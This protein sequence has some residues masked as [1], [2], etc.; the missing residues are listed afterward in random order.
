[1]GSIDDEDDSAVGA[2]FLGI[3]RNIVKTAHEPKPPKDYVDSSKDVLDAANKQK[4]VK[5]PDIRHGVSI[6]VSD[7]SKLNQQSDDD[8]NKKK[9][10][11][12]NDKEEQKEEPKKKSKKWEINEWED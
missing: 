12:D 2:A 10:K 6:S 3:N 9:K 11:E 5:K 7:A 1:M 4:V 8:K